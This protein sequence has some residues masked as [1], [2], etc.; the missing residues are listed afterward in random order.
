MIYTMVFVYPV[1]LLEEVLEFFRNP[2]EASEW[3]F[4]NEGGCFSMIFHEGH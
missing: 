4:V 1:K 3:F 2:S